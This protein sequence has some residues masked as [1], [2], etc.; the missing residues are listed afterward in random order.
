MRFTIAEGL[1]LDVSHM[2]GPAWAVTDKEIEEAAP[3]LRGA[4]EILKTIRETGKAPAGETVRFPRL[5]SLFEDDELWTD[6]E[7]ERLTELRAYAET[8]DAVI[9]V[10][11]GGSYLG[12]RVLCDACFVGETDKTHRLSVYF[13]G[14][15]ADPEAMGFLLSSLKA[16]AAKKGA[17][18]RILVISV[19]KSGTTIEPAEALSV[20]MR[21]LPQIADEI[22][23][24]AVTARGHN[25]LHGMCHENGWLHFYVPEGIGGRFSVLSQVGMIFATAIGLDT[26][27]IFAGARSAEASCQ[28]DNPRENPAF[29]LALLKYAATI[30]HGITTEITMPYS[31]RLSTFA[32]W[33]AQLL[34]ESLGKKTD[35]D[36]RVVHYGRTP[37]SAV[38]TTDMHSVTQ[39]HQEGKRDKLLQFISVLHPSFDTETE[40]M[41][42]GKSIRLPMSVIHHAALYANAE[43]LASDERMS[44]I[45]ET[46]TV[47]EY[48][49][50]ALFYFFELAIAY[51][52]ALAHVNAYDQPGVE[53]YKTFLHGELKRY[54]ETADSF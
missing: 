35:W 3:A 38:G 21:E 45:L 42:D 36:G 23:Y 18:Y 47:D 43:A 6:S 4:A 2:Y 5:L 44:V 19:S 27:K 1:T 9:S 52:G 32:Q 31:E 8:A 14:Y 37:V 12:N 15:T 25:I 10:G 13:A 48:H 49:I 50:G 20:L 53:K 29:F 26:K 40:I 51:E 24:A 33:Y 34:G 17:P 16:E 46:E 22:R 28:S 54:G 7:K 41:E 11:I 30:R 39:E